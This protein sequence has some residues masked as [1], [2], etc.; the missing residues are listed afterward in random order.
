MGDRVL[1]KLNRATHLDIKLCSSWDMLAELD[2]IYLQTTC[3]QMQIALE[4]G[5]FQRRCDWSQ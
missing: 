4:V 5:G 1:E 3:I 2:T